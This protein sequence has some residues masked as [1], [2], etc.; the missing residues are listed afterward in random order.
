MVVYV[1]RKIDIMK[2]T[3]RRSILYV[4]GDSV[5]MLEKAATLPA[6]VLLFNLEDGVA[7]A[8]KEE[9]RE[10]IAGALKSIDY[11]NRETV[12]RINPPDTETGRLDL[13]TCLPSRPHGICLPKVEAAGTVTALAAAL[14]EIEKCDG[15]KEGTIRIHAM[16]ESAAGLLRAHEIASCSPR[17]SSLI[18]G[19]ADYIADI[20][21]RPGEDRLELLY[22]LQVIVTSARAAG[23]EAI[24]A[25]CFDLHNKE[26]LQREA[27]Q[28]RRL[29]F[30]GKS[31]LHPGQLALINQAFDVS[32]EE[33]EWAEKTIAELDAAEGRGKALTTVEGKL[34][35]NPHRAAAE[36]ILRRRKS[37]DTFPP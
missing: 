15:M 35:D 22:A 28:A 24:D 4:P 1:R 33:I 16:I 9:A 31:A 19:S 11:G 32:A 29:G 8:R 13:A 10:N 26:L 6:D 36:R 21:C 27:V 37:V 30:D 3:V 20:G 17:V 5:K 7:S 2:I 12:V 23:I 25:P 14:S 18:F 34:L